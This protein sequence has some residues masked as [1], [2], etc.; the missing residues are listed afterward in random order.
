MCFVCDVRR[1]AVCYSAYYLF[2]MYTF[3]TSA[4]LRKHWDLFLSDAHV[5]ERVDERTVILQ[6]FFH[7]P[8]YSSV[9]PPLALGFLLSKL[10]S[11]FPFSPL[12]F[13]LRVTVLIPIF[14]QVGTYVSP[15]YICCRQ[16]RK[17]TCKR[18][19]VYYF[20]LS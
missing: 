15:P 5:L 1:F 3:A 16:D 19:L 11:F 8:W 12:F 18:W 10:P 7:P 6:Y 14:W 17:T 4:A 20:S 2:Q 13:Y 9:L